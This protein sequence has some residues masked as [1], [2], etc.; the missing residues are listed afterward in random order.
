MYAFV[1]QI[2]GLLK[3]THNFVYTLPNPTPVCLTS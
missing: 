3:T 2:I 1:V